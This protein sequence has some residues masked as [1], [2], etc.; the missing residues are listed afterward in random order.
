LALTSDG[1]QIASIQGL[2]RNTAMYNFST[3][4]SNWETRGSKNKNS[5]LF[6]SL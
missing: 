5:K 6:C 3:G 2:S 4:T 1:R